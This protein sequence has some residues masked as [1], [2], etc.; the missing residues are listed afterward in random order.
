[1]KKVLICILITI[2]IVPIMCLLYEIKLGEESI[3]E[4]QNFCN[5][6][7]LKEKFN[8]VPNKFLTKLSNNDFQYQKKPIS[9]VKTAICFVK[10]DD[11]SI[12]IEKKIKNLN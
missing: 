1:M 2:I 6:I 10:L 11:Q 12:V 3:T 9:F 7:K 8:I 5:N 4:A